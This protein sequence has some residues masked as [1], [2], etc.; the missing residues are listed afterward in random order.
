MCKNPTDFFT[1]G[2][3]LTDDEQ[4]VGG[5]VRLKAFGKKQSRK[6]VVISRENDRDSTTKERIIE[7]MPIVSRFIRIT[8]SG[9]RTESYK[10]KR[11]TLKSAA[12][13]RI[14]KKE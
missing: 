5:W 3:L 8:D 10:R 7:S 2:N 6:F 4:I 1:G 11:Q 12:R 14:I 13:R 9:E